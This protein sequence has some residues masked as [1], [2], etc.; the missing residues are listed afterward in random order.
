MTRLPLTQAQCAALTWELDARNPLIGPPWPSPVIADP[1]VLPP[2]ETP[3]QRWH[4]IAHSLLGIHHFVSDDGVDW[5]SRRTLRRNALRA[6][7]TRISEGEYALLMEKPRLMVPIGPL[8]WR[9]VIQSQR[10]H[11]LSTWTRPVTVLEP[12]LAWHHEPGRG[13]AVGNPCLI[14]VEEGW[15]LYYSAGLVFLEDCGFCEPRWIGLK[16]QE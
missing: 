3:D 13:S 2:E 11:D 5:D 8:P 4:L 10:S 14:R 7:L 15:R 6:H 12:S 16:L 1:T 9:S